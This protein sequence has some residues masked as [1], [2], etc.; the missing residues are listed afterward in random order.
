MSALGPFLKQLFATGEARLAGR[1]DVDDRREAVGVLRRAFAEYRLEVAGP[2]VE[3]DDEAGLAAAVFT[4]RACWF[5]VSR[6]EPPEEVS[7][8]LSPLRQPTTPAAHL[9][10]DL[11]LRYAVTVHRRARAQNPEDVLVKGLAETLRGCPLTGVLSDVADGPTGDLT[12]GGHRG[13]EL[14][15]AERLAGHFR[16][17]WLPPEGRTREAVE[18]VFRQLGRAWPVDVSGSPFPLREGG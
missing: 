4:A 3:F 6:D 12:F 18:L 17:G 1:P 13:L 2:P 16:D 14:L 10:A 15:Y 11:T 8:S 9:S 7:K 5:A